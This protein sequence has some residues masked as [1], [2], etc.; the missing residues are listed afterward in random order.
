MP[1]L[2]DLEVFARNLEKRF[3]NKRLQQLEVNIAK[4]LNVTTAELKTALEGVVLK[5]VSR[6]GKTLQLHF[7]NGAVL[8]LHLMLHGKLQLLSTDQEIKHAI[9]SFRFQ[10]GEGFVLTDFQKAATPTLNPKP[11]DVP[12]AMGKEMSLE[13]LSGLLSKRRIAIKSVLMDQHAIR[14]IGNTYADEILWEA[15]ISPFSVSKAIPDAKVKVLHKAIQEILAKEVLQIEKQLEGAIFG[16]IH[17]FLKIHR[18]DLVKS[19]G[20]AEI[21]VR[22]IGGRKAYYTDEQILFE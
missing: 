17:D 5:H 10:G 22:E 9:I 16:E 20:G 19:P 7:K 18:P 2:P 15:R 1:E 11:N 12:D 21:K 3:K 13:Y 14:G 4:K 8:G 6:E